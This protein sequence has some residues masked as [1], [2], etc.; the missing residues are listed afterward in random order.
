[1]IDSVVCRIDSTHHHPSVFSS[2]GEEEEEEKKKKIFKMSLKQS[3]SS[4]SLV[5]VV[6]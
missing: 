1:M 5:V 3:L 4:L 6:W 2:R